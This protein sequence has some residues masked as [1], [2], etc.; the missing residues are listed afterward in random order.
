MSRFDNYISGRSDKPNPGVPNYGSPEEI[1][2][3]D[4]IKNLRSIAASA[5]VIAKFFGEAA[6]NSKE[7]AEEV[8]NMPPPEENKKP[9]ERTGD[10][11]F[12]YQL[13]IYNMAA[14]LDLV[15]GSNE[16]D[17]TVTVTA[18]AADINNPECCDITI[19]MRSPFKF[20]SGFVVSRTFIPYWSELS[21]VALRYGTCNCKLFCNYIQLF[22]EET[23][24]D[25]D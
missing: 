19:T 4:V 20:C 24:N 7:V 3:A 2:Q 8:S 18:T 15:Y 17:Y 25:H 1:F 9:E 5:E 12:A 10:P 21:G 16:R 23:N 22:K 6:E 11:V 14:N 13:L